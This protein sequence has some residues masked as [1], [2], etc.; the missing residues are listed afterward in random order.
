[1]REICRLSVGSA[2]VLLRVAGGLLLMVCACD[3]DRKP[4]N[5]ALATDDAGPRPTI[6]LAQAQFFET[7][8]EATGDV[9]TRPGA[10]RLVILRQ[11]ADEW[12]REVLEDAESNVF[13]KAVFFTDP[14]KPDAGPGI[15]T[16][17]ANGAA[18]K[19]WH[20]TADGWT[21]DTL[22]KTEFG[23]RQNRLRDFEVGDVTGDGKVDI[24][25]ATHDQ[26]VVAVLR[27]TDGGWEPIELDR[28]NRTYVHEVEL[29]DLDGDGIREIYATPSKPNKLDGTPQPGEIVSYHYTKDGF[30]RRTVEE[31]PLRH[32]KEILATDVDGSDRPALLAAVEAEQAQRADGPPDADRTLIKRYR[33]ENGRYAGEVV[34]TLPDDMC[35]FL[36]AGDVDGDGK[37][38][39]IA[40]TR[41]AG[42]RLARPGSSEWKVELVDADSTSEIEHATTL[43]D[44]DGDGVLEIYVVTDKHNEVR[45]YRWDGTQWDR[46]VVAQFEGTT[47]TFG[48]TAAMSDL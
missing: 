31:F 25:I 44:L 42:V 37:P 24:V 22:W 28:K 18:V 6:L 35:R 32:V 19:V 45:R 10:A 17:G 23:G 26:G 33:L 38:E 40:S 14:T 36:N 11:S 5:S 30:E 15:L 16:I 41:T 9:K 21:A 8:D 39:L 43:A 27:Q 29:G 48:I 4:G 34:G 47:I 13:H 2:R 1:M 7:T 20:K 3:N 46:A 12:K